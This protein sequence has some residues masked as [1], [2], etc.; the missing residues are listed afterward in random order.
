[1]RHRFTRVVRPAPGAP[2]TGAPRFAS[3]VVVSTLAVLLAACTGTD[4]GETAATGTTS[5]PASSSAAA[6]ADSTVSPVDTDSVQTDA[7]VTS[8]ALVLTWAEYSDD[9]GTIDAAAFV[10]GVVET[11]GTCLLTATRRGEEHTSDPTPAEPGPSTTDCG[12]LSIQLPGG[13]S[14]SWDVSVTY[15]SSTAGDLTSETTKV[16]VP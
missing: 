10:Q 1:M 15:S 13:S 12:P 3:A 6:A 9:D 14:G 8:S 16:Q 2:G 5:A 11:G 4:T 7:P